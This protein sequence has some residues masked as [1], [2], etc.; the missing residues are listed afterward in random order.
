MLPPPP[1]PP[2]DQYFPSFQ[3]SPS[4]VDPGPR[5]SPTPTLAPGLT[6]SSFDYPKIPDSTALQ[7]SLEVRDNLGTMSIYTKGLHPK[8]ALVTVSTVIQQIKAAAIAFRSKTNII[9]NTHTHMPAISI[10]K[11]GNEITLAHVASQASAGSKV[12]YPAAAGRDA[13]HGAADASKMI[14]SA[15]LIESWE[16]LNRSED[17]DL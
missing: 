1:A 16:T 4:A 15:L 10:G 7:T 2:R 3:L 6:A 5:S 12:G 17:D 13:E 14:W 8:S 9:D 11:T